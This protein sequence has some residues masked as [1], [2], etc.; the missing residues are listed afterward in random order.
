VTQFLTVRKFARSR[1][2][3]LEVIG[4]LLVLEANPAGDHTY[5]LPGE[6]PGDVGTVERIGIRRVA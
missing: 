1:A 3:Y 5:E 4:P 6:R 2:V